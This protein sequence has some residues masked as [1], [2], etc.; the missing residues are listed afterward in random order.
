MGTLLQQAAPV[1]ISLIILAALALLWRT[2]RSIWLIVAVIGEIVGLVFRF[3][4]SFSP[5]LARSMPMLFTLWSLSA[6]V[7]AIGLFGYALEQHAS[8]QSRKARQ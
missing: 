8:D 4:V 5:E 7:F 6:F 2:S 3:V 1:I